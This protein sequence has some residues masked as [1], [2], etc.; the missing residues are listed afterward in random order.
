MCPYCSNAF[1]DVI[2]TEN[3]GTWRRRR[4]RCKNCQGEFHTKEEFN[5]LIKDPPGA[6][7]VE[8]SGNFQDPLLEKT[9]N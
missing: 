7:P 1:S 2:S 6:T 3:Y 5:G 4:R 9:G 8:N